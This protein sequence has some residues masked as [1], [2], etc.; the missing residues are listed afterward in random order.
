MPNQRKS[1]LQSHG[2]GPFQVLERINDNTYKIDLPGEYSV[3]A[4]FNV[5]DLTSYQEETLVHLSHVQEGSN[6]TLF[7]PLGE[8]SK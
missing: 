2:D 7:G 6:T 5:V 3:S 4:T 8:D 1:K